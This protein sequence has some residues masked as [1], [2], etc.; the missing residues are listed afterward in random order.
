VITLI[1]PQHLLAAAL[2]AAGLLMALATVLTEP[3]CALDWPVVVL[4]IRTVKGIRY[5][6]HRLEHENGHT[7]GMA[8]KP[9][10]DATDPMTTIPDLR[11]A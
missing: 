3:G 5:H 9:D 2:V 4:A 6:R 10:P 7:L 1:D 8:Y 11:T